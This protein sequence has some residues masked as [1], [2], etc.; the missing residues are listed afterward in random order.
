M[1]FFL[2]IPDDAE[3][4]IN[5]LILVLDVRIE[6]KKGVKVLQQEFHWKIT[7][8]VDKSFQNDLRLKKNEHAPF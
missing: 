8:D 2:M 4:L 1:A 7:W 3:T 5:G 6:K